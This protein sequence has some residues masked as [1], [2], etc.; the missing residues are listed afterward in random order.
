MQRVLSKACVAGEIGDVVLFCEHEPV[1]ALGRPRESLLNSGIEA[2]QSERGDVTWGKRKIAALGVA[3]GLEGRGVTS[4]AKVPSL[5]EVFSRMAPKL[6][7][8][9]NRK[10][11]NLLN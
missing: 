11:C 8:C 4:M 9:L 2:V 5:S 6:A 1:I 3:C 7:R 10:L